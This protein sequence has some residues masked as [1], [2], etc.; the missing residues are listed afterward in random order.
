MV[1]N[2]SHEAHSLLVVKLGPTAVTLTPPRL[3]T[4]F[5]VSLNFYYGTRDD[6]VTVTNWSSPTSVENLPLTTR[7]KSRTTQ[8]QLYTVCTPSHVLWS[9]R[10]RRSFTVSG[11][12]KV[13]ECR[14]SE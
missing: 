2:L 8:T 9:Y 13:G 11:G 4:S 14:A 10:R 5:T 6:G 3:P 7:T 12:L 1:P